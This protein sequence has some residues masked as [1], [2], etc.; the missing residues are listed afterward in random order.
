MKKR[1]IY[2][3]IMIISGVYATLCGQN[4]SE[5]EKE[6][7]NTRKKIEYTRKLI[8]ETSKKKEEGITQLG[9]IAAEIELRGKVIDNITFELELLEEDV[10]KRQKRIGLLNE[11]LEKEMD[12]YRNVIM[13]AFRETK[14]YQPLTFVLSSENFNQAYKRI[15][16]MQKLARYRQAKSES[17][18]ESRKELLR[19]IASLEEKRKEKNKLLEEK[20]KENDEL[21]RRKSSQQAMIARLRNQEQKLRKELKESE[22]IA[23]RLEKTIREIISAEAKRRETG[24]MKLSPEQELIDHNFRNNKG[25]L[26]WPTERGIITGLFGEHEHPVLKGVKLNNNGIDITTEKGSEARALF[27]GEVSLVTTI[28]GANRVVIIRHGNYLTMYANLIDVYVR[29]G[30]KVQVKQKIGKIFTD[31]DNEGKTVIHLEIWEEN[32]KLNP[33]QWLSAE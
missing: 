19:E 26:P 8:D 5:L 13:Q 18:K 7:E 15:K 20:R 21:K 29:T 27:D 6:K 4:L 32:E 31:D 22:E 24:K 10:E 1:R 28:P 11:E 33:Q 25:R 2:V 30:E 23:A 14:C 17:I 3:L 12:Q 16:Y 9:F